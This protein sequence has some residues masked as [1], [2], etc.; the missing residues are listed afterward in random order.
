MAAASWCPLIWEIW[1]QQNIQNKHTTFLHSKMPML[2]G[3]AFSL[4]LSL[5]LSLSFLYSCFT[6]GT[7]ILSIHMEVTSASYRS[8]CFS[9]YHC[10]NYFQDPI[11]MAHT[12]CLLGTLCKSD[13]SL[14]TYNSWNF[15]ILLS[16]CT[17]HHAS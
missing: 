14:Q 11:F 4:S 7:S 16:S 10:S 5:S 17:L 15:V 9:F 1:M 2:L 13:K 12:M 6:T 3:I 8:C